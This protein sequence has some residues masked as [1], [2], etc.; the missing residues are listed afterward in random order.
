M[1]IQKGY[2]PLIL[3]QSVCEMKGYD[4]DLDDIINNIKYVFHFKN[5]L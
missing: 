3:M 2:E 4:C 1:N 5:E